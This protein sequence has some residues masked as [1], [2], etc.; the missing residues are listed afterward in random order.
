MVSP[1]DVGG[2]LNSLWL[3]GKGIEGASV[4]ASNR[5]ERILLKGANRCSLPGFKK[6]PEKEK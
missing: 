1:S 4:S 6:Y 5:S 2:N 3:S